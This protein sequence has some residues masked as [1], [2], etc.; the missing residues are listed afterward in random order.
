[1]QPQRVTRSP[2]LGALALA[3][4]TCNG[5]EIEPTTTTTY[6]PATTQPIPE[7]TLASSST[8]QPSSTTSITGDDTSE[9]T[10][11]TSGHP[12][13]T[14]MVPD[15]GEPEYDCNGKIDILIVFDRHYY[16][17]NFWP[18]MA[19]ALP[20]VLPMMVE[21]FA[22]FDTHWM[23]ANPYQNWGIVACG[24]QCAQ[25]N[26]VNCDPIG[27]P[28]YPCQP[29][30]DDSLS[31]CDKTR[32]AGFLFPAG[33]ASANKRCE[34]AG[35]QRWIQSSVTDDLLGELSCITETG[36]TDQNSIM[37]ENAMVQALEPPITK[38]PGGC[39]FGFLRDDALLF[40]VLFTGYAGIDDSIA[41]TPKDW[42]ETIYYAKNGDRDKVV[43]LG[44]GT[45]H[46]HPQDVSV[47]GKQG[48]LDYSSDIESF[49]RFEIDHAVQG[50]NCAD[51]Y[52][53]FF[54][55]GLK[56]A[57]EMCGEQPPT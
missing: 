17:E 36:W 32:G 20:V 33:Y 26:G 46:T 28:D 6:A 16:I 1:M 25:N 24:S 7:P 45:D 41:G 43:V 8:A 52:V 37:A 50:S 15:F 35:G 38:I 54:E 53:P 48:T 19:E 56:L 3:I 42:A 10:T 39:N 49:L 5:P 21:W 34:F 40:I 23:V 18:T 29:H 12:T 22:N 57:L 9:D 11:S 30:L 55:S 4:C 44:I 47:C 13:E 27:P 51:D 2:Q 31:D 14:S